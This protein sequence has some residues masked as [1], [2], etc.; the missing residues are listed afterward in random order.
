M[1]TLIS[2]FVYATKVHKYHPHP[3]FYGEVGVPFVELWCL[4]I[5]FEIDI[6]LILAVEVNSW[7]I[8]QKQKNLYT[9]LANPYL[10]L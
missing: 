1:Q 4:E 8:G 9:R 6:V 10:K 2:S 3:M 5:N 7:L